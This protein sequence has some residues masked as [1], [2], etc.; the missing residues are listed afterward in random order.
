VPIELKISCRVLES[1]DSRGSIQRTSQA[2]ASSTRV[3]DFTLCPLGQPKKAIGHESQIG[4]CV[5]THYR[6][7]L[8]YRSQP[9]TEKLQWVYYLKIDPSWDYGEALVNSAVQN[10][11]AGARARIISI[12]PNCI[13]FARSDYPLRH[14][15]ETSIGTNMELGVA[16]WISYHARS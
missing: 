2:R 12:R 15:H 5:A 6:L 7:Q 11:A 1:S 14:A 8:C 13:K 9:E 3:S 4:P 10:E 16:P